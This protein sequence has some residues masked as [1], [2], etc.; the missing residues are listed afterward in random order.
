MLSPL[1]ST[2]GA[3]WEGRALSI[4]QEHLV[5]VLVRNLLGA[6]M[7][8]RPPATSGITLFAT[9]PG[10]AHELGIV[11]AAS[12]ASMRGIRV[13]VLGS[14]LPSAEI[15]RAARYLRPTAIVIGA[16]LAQ[17]EVQRCVAA[18]RAKTPVRTKILLG[19]PVAVRQSV[20]V[21]GVDHVAT[22]SEFAD[23]LPQYA[24]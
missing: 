19:G 17:P 13:S 10:E 2:V 8:Q 6:L 5:S 21:P 20:S 14:G 11:L 18:V 7:R 22:L 12:L 24:A 15:L 4:A 1:M 23:R 16:M 3:L 9:P